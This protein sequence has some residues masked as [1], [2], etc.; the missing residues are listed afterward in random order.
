MINIFVKFFEG[1]CNF[2]CVK[3]VVIVVVLKFVKYCMLKNMIGW[4][5]CF[6][7]VILSFLFKNGFLN[8]LWLVYVFDW[9]VLVGFRLGLFIEVGGVDML[10]VFLLLDEGVVEVGVVLVICR[11]V[12]ELV[13][14]EVVE[15][16]V[17][18]GVVEWGGRFWIILICVKLG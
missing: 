16:C 15:L 9:L 5:K 6:G 18:F 3:L 8:G 11:L 7:W 17:V 13:S 4:V 14:D 10:E 1:M 12:K 2:K